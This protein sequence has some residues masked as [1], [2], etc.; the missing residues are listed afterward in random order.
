[1]DRFNMDRYGFIWTILYGTYDMHHMII[2]E[3][4]PEQQYY[5]FQQRDQRTLLLHQSLTFLESKH[6]PIRRLE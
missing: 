3:T 1:M 5:L 2:F 6:T 4:D